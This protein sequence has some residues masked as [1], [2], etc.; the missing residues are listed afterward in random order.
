[1]IN[2]SDL[3]QFN[4]L[5]EIDITSLWGLFEH[6]AIRNLDKGDVL[7]SKGDV[8][9]T[10]FFVLLGS[11]SVHLDSPDSEP[12]AFVEGGQTVGELSVIDAAPVSA[13][14]VAAE[15]LRL[16]S[17]EEDT[18]W[19]L[20]HASHEFAANMLLLLVQRMRSTNKTV[21][22]T[23][24]QKKQFERDALFDR[25]TG[26]HN[27]RWLDKE[28]P[29]IAQRSHFDNCPIC[30]LMTDIDHFKHFNDT[31]GHLS[32]DKVLATVAKTLQKNVR[33]LDMVARYGGEE[34]IVILT[35]TDIHGAKIAAERIRKSVS[36]I[37]LVLDS[38]DS[39]Q[40]TISIGAAQFFPQNNSTMVIDR[41]DEALYNA[42]NN[43]RNRVECWQK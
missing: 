27:R 29:R 42:K 22:Q 34:F 11:L 30:V 41:A 43:G 16:M 3:N 2:T 1:M 28:L 35:N 9:H 4:V 26:L 39:P 5:H 24:V 32:G 21:S 17:V 19:R 8:N 12:V 20:I 6:C 7:L 38:G 13:Y 31:Y 33:P 25:L 18:F 37:S 10:M 23:T 40:V 14:V 15:P 36:E